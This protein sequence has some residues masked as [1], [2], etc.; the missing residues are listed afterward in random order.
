M[1]APHGRP[2]TASR[3]G[4]MCVRPQGRPYVARYHCVLWRVGSGGCAL[5]L[6]LL[7]LLLLASRVG[8]MF[9]RLELDMRARGVPAL[10]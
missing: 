5:L 6:L 3:V 4:R 10:S 8:R 9:V 1:E 7:L 2:V